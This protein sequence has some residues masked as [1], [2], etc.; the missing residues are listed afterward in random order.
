MLTLNCCLCNMSNSSIV[1]LGHLKQINVAQ[2]LF[3]ITGKAPISVS[4]IGSLVICKPSTLNCTFISEGDKSGDNKAAMETAELSKLTW[5][6]RALQ[7]RERI[8]WKKDNV[9]K[10]K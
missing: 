3:S 10:V 6:L 9:S 4:P 2:K 1:S 8:K 7:N 5:R